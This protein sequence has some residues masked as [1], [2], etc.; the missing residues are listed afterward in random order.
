[1]PAIE[2]Q[3]ITKST[4]NNH[5][6]VSVEDSLDKDSDKINSIQSKIDVVGLSLE[7]SNFKWICY[8][9]CGKNIVNSRLYMNGRN[10]LAYDLN[11]VVILKKLKENLYFQVFN[12]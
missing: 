4:K 7:K 1:M 12:Q 3:V 9:C 6:E 11:I 10:F 5:K 2:I 8:M